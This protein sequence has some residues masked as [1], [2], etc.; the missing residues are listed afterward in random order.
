MNW[1]MVF[2][3]GNFI[4]EWA[5]CCCAGV[6]LCVCFCRFVVVVFFLNADYT[7]AVLFYRFVVGTLSCAAFLGFVFAD[8]L[9]AIVF[10]YS[11][12]HFLAPL[13]FRLWVFLFTK[14]I[15]NIVSTISWESFIKLI[16]MCIFYIIKRFFYLIN[17]LFSIN[18][19]ISRMLLFFY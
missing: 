10:F 5:I 18:L 9:S 6:G 15:K 4:F 3:F 13:L 14:K 1:E 11:L 16:P 19:F 12:H 17:F 8:W 2:R 7:D